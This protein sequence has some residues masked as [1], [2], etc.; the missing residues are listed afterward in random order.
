VQRGDCVVAFS[1]RDVHALRHEIEAATP[2]RAC[3]VYGALPPDARRM[4]AQLFDTPRSGFG[5]LAASGGVGLGGQAGTL[6]APA[7]HACTTRGGVSS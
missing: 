3:V 1:R 6:C 2:H 5:V 7:L 4:Q